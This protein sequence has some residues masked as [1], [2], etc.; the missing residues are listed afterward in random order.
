MQVLRAKFPGTLLVPDVCT[1]QSLPKVRE[2]GEG[3]TLDSSETR[4]QVATEGEGWRLP[5]AA[6]A[7]IKHTPL[8]HGVGRHMHS[9]QGAT[10]LHRIPLLICQSNCWF[11]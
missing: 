3:E 4:G 7:L 2:E 1:L 6:P 5:C 10:R 8:T 9:P 11:A